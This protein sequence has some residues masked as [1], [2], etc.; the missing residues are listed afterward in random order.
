MYQIILRLSQLVIFLVMKRRASGQEKTPREGSLLIVSNHLG[1]LDPLAIGTSLPRRLYILSKA[2]VF[3][4]PVL[5]WLARRADVIPIHRGQ[6]D[7]EAIRH[8]LEHLEAG[9]AVLLFPEG[10]YP[11]SH[12]PRGMLKAQ[13]GAALLAQR[14]GA[15]ILPVGISGSD[16]VWSPR[17]L[18]WGLF[19]RWPVEVRV[20]DPYRPTVPASVSQKQALALITEE[21][22][23]SIAALL[24]E[25][26]RGVYRA[27]VSDTET[28]PTLPAP[29]PTPDPL[30][31]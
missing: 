24:P 30:P 3:S 25:S 9:H 15:T 12:Q 23:R 11:K 13:A 10:T 6:S 7:R 21:M 2:E 16:M 17:T 26:Y 5:G 20:G 4:W 18:P 22:M 19:R 28:Q 14:S 27:A 8:V 29:P 31:G 1:L